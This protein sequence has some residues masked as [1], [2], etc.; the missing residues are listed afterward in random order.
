MQQDFEQAWLGKL[1]RGLDTIVGEE[2]REAVMR[3]GEPLSTDPGPEEIA[4]WTRQLME[5][6]V[7]MLGQN[8]AR[9]AMTRCACEYPKARLQPIR[10]EYERTRDVGS[11]V[12]MLQS[13]FET[14]LRDDLK[15]SDELADRVISLGWGVAGVLDGNTIISTKIPKS[16]NLVTYFAEP[17]PMLKRR[18]YCHCPRMRYVL[19]TSGQ[20]P[21]LYCYCG[22]G[23]Y[24][25]IWEEILQSTVEVEVLESVLGGGDVCRI[26]IHLPPDT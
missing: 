12:R 15:L 25:G 19:Q 2:M 26:A 10:Q 11:A 1:V 18:L 9:E 8:K 17:D 5:R 16:G 24:K 6:M 7:T 22:A 4:D 14:F 23:F 3:G 13:G 21:P 20:M